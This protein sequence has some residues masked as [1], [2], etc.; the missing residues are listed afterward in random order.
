MMDYSHILFY[1]VLY[2]II[3]ILYKKN[4]DIIIKSNLDQIKHVKFLYTKIIIKI[5]KININ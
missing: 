1:I 3:K 2:I 4:K 5:F